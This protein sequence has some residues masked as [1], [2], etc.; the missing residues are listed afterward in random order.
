[1]NKIYRI[2]WSRVRNAFVVVSELAHSQGKAATCDRRRQVT[3]R[4]S[5]QAAAGVAPKLMA[6][7][8]LCATLLCLMAAPVWADPAANALPTGGQITAGAGT[9]STSG[10]A[11]T[12]QQNTQQLIANWQSFD[13]GANA[14]VTFQQPSS[15]SIALNRITGQ[16]PSQIMGQLNANGQVML[17][18]PAGIIFGQGSQVNV[19]GITATTLDISDADFLADNFHFSNSGHAGSVENLGHILAHGGVVALV[20]PVV[21]NAGVIETANG[22]SVLAAGD[23]VT[24]DFSGDGLVTVTVSQ[25]RL[26]NLVANNGA[27]RADNGLVI[28]TAGAASDVLS[29]VVNNSGIVE[30]KGLSEQGGRI[31]LGGGEVTNDGLLDVGSEL[32]RGGDI[33]ISGKHIQL[34][35]NSDIVASGATGGGTVHVGGEWQGGG[36]MPQAETVS[37]NEG[38]SIDASATQNGD[39]GEIVLWSDVGNQASH[40]RVAGTLKAEGGSQSGN[41]GRI[42]TSGHTLSI[43]DSTQVSTK[44]AQGDAG[45]WLLDPQDFTIAASGGDISGA[46]LSANL[47]SGNV[48]VLSSSGGTS[49]SGDI[50]VNDTVS[51]S[52]NTLTLTAAHD[53]NINN[54]MTATGA[55]ALTMNTAAA[56]GADSGVADGQVKV[57]ITGTGDSASFSGRVDYSASGALTINGDVYTVITS[58]GSGSTDTTAGTLQGMQGDLTKHYALGADIDASATSTWNAGAGFAPIGNSST[59]YTGGGFDGLGHTITGLTINKPTTDYVGL[60]GYG[61]H[62][63]FRNV[64]LINPTVVG[65]QYVG[66]LVGYAYTDTAGSGVH[67]FNLW[68][69]GV[70][71]TAS[72]GGAGGLFGYQRV[73]GK[74]YTG[75]NLHTTGT[76]NSGSSYTGGI[77]GNF[78]IANATGV[79]RDSYSSAVIVGTGTGTGG[80]AGG[81]SGADVDNVHATGNVSGGGYATGGL[82]GSFY[83]GSTY[84]LTN[85]YATG[86]ISI[87]TGGDVGGLVG[88]LS[89]EVVGSY[90]TGTVSGDTKVGGLVG[91]IYLGATITNSHA[92]GTASGDTKVGGLVGAIDYGG[93]ITNSYATGGV[94]STGDNAGGLVG[95]IDGTVN[96][97]TFGNLTITD[98]YATG[99]VNGGGLYIG[100]LIGQVYGFDG[101]VSATT[102]SRTFTFTNLYATGNVTGGTCTGGAIGRIYSVVNPSPTSNAG[103][104]TA[105]FNLDNVYYDNGVVSGVGNVGGLIGSIE[106]LEYGSNASSFTFRHNLTLTNLHSTATSVTGSGSYSGGLIGSLSQGANG[107]NGRVDVSLS[108]S[109]SIADVSSSSY[110]VGGLIGNWNYTTNGYGNH[111]NINRVYAEGN[112]GAVGGAGGLIGIIQATSASADNTFT[113]TDAYARGDVTQTGTGN[114]LGGLI[115][116][117][118]TFSSVAAPIS[119]ARTYA[120]GLVNNGISATNVGGLIGYNSNGSITNSFWD[121]QTSGLTTSAG[122]TGKTTAEMTTSTAQAMYEGVGWDFSYPGGTWG[123]STLLNDYYPILQ[124]LP[125]RI[126]VQLDLNNLIKTYGDANPGL[127]GE[128]SILTGCSGCVTDLNWATSGTNYITNSTDAGTY[129]YL[130][131]YFTYSFNA[132][133]A[134]DYVVSF[135]GNALTIDPL[136]LSVTGSWTA[137]DKSYDG[138]TLAAVNAGSLS[139]SGV[140]FGDDVSLASASASFDDKNAGIDKTVTLD[141]F[142][143]SGTKAGNYTVAA[144][145]GLSSTDLA[146]ITPKSLSVSGSFTAS[147]K[148]YD[149]TTTASI[150]VSGLT[151]DT[152]SVISGDT[153]SLD[154]ASATGDFDDK[155]AATGKTVSLS[156]GA[157]TGA[158][159]GNY[160]LSGSATATADIT[161]KTITLSA[162]KTYDGTTSLTGA[163]TLGGLV[164][165]ETLS[166]TGAV[167]SDANVA[168]ANKYISGI[169]LLNGGN[170]GLAT[171]YQLPTLNSANAP[172]HLDRWAH[173]V[174][175]QD[176]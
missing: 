129:E 170:G 99:D 110:W 128:W 9:I 92:T 7:R 95:Y 127:S 18:N 69:H 162:S 97:T 143:L 124:A 134:D 139:L 87:S 80:L 15:S 45:E 93:T 122:G 119:I 43:K 35:D 16:N 36:E 77:A 131:D 20:A 173:R 175:E 100:G 44:A 176:L 29:G 123:I 137:S 111:I 24:L 64:G 84:S 22:S 39:G 1:M 31:V 141:G 49:G 14:S 50:N 126:R 102:Y 125:P 56:N 37:M 27:I 91:R 30:A 5:S 157:L 103:S 164:G 115:G 53:I 62:A 26:D 153:V 104:W 140:L 130:S 116:Y 105:N 114:N 90:A 112:A 94:T 168:T 150:N 25:S 154:L 34:A 68:A 63:S 120:T 148:V 85:S 59:Q 149:G 133:T 75:A 81:M 79:L 58:L 46:T 89:G 98:S 41:G 117:V 54:V 23:E 118:Y 52:A 21:N 11:M 142:G 138:N 42:E 83:G 108:D 60:F 144:D 33:E 163:V 156:D 57:G 109:Y 88:I 38:A 135:S 152:G 61:R 74:T 151:L 17:V 169:T 51:W 136:Q 71:V 121:T 161:A 82:F 32:D 10:N 96:S 6:R 160:T 145:P 72:N 12:V 3:R 4:N 155:N 86:N 8:L 171:N 2:I 70:D 166:Y 132:G 40:T 76:V 19:G 167:A 172:V 165:T 65:R 28:L 113:L 55:A 174:G 78:E 107:S 67:N 48:S 147:D 66:P 101:A 159:A 146:N 158:D 13:I 73:A 106:L 47:G